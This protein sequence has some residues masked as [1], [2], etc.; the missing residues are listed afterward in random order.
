MS[1]LVVFDDTEETKKQIVLRFNEYDS[2]F[3][4][5]YIISKETN[6]DINMDYLGET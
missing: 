1:K 2:S 4:A 5:N 6:F 3:M